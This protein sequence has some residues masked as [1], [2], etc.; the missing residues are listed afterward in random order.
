MINKNR[1]SRLKIKYKEIKAKD[2]IN[3]KFLIL[4]I[5]ENNNFKKLFEVN[6]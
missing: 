3:S 5:V 6:Y 4:N 1:F 2:F